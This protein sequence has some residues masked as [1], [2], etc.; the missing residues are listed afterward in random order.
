MRKSRQETASTRRRIVETAAV[1]FR[2]SG[3]AGAGVADV[4]EAT[5]LTQGAFYRHF[6]SKQQ[7]LT[8]ALD[9]SVRQLRASFQEA[10]QRRP[11]TAGVVAVIESYLSAD[12]RDDPT[13]C[14][15]VALGSELARESRAVRETATTGFQILAQVLSEHLTLL[16]RVAAKKEALTLLSLMVGA[17]TVAKFVSDKEMSKSI[18]AQARKDLIE[19]VRRHW[20]PE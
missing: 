20:K 8:E 16:S 17:L 1:E 14:P 10:F 11:G 9:Q 15:F 13:F 7:L 5:G 4:M 3:I 2:R 6:K 12:H 18:L 19:Q